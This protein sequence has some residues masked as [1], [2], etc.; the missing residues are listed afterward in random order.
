MLNA[1]DLQNVMKSHNSFID[2]IETFE[3]ESVALKNEIDELK[4]TLNT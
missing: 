2:D 1:A 3:K 4:N